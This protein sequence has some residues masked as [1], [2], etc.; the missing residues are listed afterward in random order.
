[1]S[2]CAGKINPQQNS[3][4]SKSTMKYIWAS[5]WLAAL[6]MRYQSRIR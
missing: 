6:A 2:M 5:D 4:L 1:M 3:F